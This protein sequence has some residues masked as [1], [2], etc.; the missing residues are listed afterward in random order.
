MPNIQKRI[1][2]YMF[3]ITMTMVS[4][5]LVASILLQINGCQKRACSD[6]ALIFSQIRQIMEENEEELAQIKEAYTNTCFNNATAIARLIQSDPSV[7]DSVESLNKIAKFM[8]VDEIHIFDETGTIYTGTHPEYY[9]FSFDS[10]EQMMFFKPMLSD[11]SLRLVQDITPNTAENKP[12]QYSAVWSDN[13]E[14]I[15]QIGMEPVNVMKATE[16]NELSYIFSLLRAGTGDMLY[17]VDSE[18]G[19]I[20]GSTVLADNRKALS[21][22]GLDLDRVTTDA[23]G[24]HAVINGVNC[25]CIFTQM[26][27]NLVGRIIPN[28][29]LYSELWTNTLGLAVGLLI[30]AVILVAAVSAYMNKYVISGIYDI[31]EKLESIT[32]GNLDET[33]NIQTSLEFS[34]LSSHINEMVE[35]LLASTDKLSYV[36]NKSNLCIGVYEY[37]EK[38]QSVRYTE[39]LPQILDVDSEKALPLFSDCKLFKAFIEQL[40]C[41]TVPDKEGVYS[42]GSEQSHFV[43]LD[44]LL[45]G[46]DILG[47]AIDVTDEILMRRKIEAELDIDPLTKLFNRRGLEKR[48]NQLFLEPEKLGYGAIIMIDADGLKNINDRYGHEMGD[49]YLKKISGILSSFGK[50]SFIAARLGGDEFVIFLYHYASERE[51]LDSIDTLHYM[52]GHSS[53][54][55]SADLCVPLKF[56][57]GYSLTEG[58]TNYTELL[59]A[60]DEKMYADKRERKKAA[61]L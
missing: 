21:D 10:G 16:K 6:S 9:N 49:I 13:G 25:F 37:N 39:R 4:V 20:V 59:K 35:A 5:I 14:F 60:A 48:L 17:A 38:M 57:F 32:D 43:K 19:K 27:S 15:V 56:S 36:L 28:R 24:F 46:N 1:I 61:T 40:R 18:S 22:I 3:G 34:R 26:D 2:K 12:M 30:T 50:N 33:V 31:N 55:L 41:N 23:D 47:I 54:H 29:I 8:E 45:K 11:K 7:L 42:V 51:L 44:E 53:A 58:E 52:Q